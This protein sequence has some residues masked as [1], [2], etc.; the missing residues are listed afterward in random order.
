MPDD[1]ILSL[2]LVPGGRHDLTIH[3]L[4]AEAGWQRQTARR[5]SGLLG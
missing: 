4:I 3:R 2:I 5:W 1:F